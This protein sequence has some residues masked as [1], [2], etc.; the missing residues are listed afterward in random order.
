MWIEFIHE[1]IKLKHGSL[2]PITSE[3]NTVTNYFDRSTRRKMTMAQT[4][5]RN[6][7]EG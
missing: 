5:D 7:Q 6:A 1:A 2:D 4:Q 3:L